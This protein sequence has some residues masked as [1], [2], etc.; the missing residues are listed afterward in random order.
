MS[1]L[2]VIP[3]ECMRSEDVVD[4]A[5]FDTSDPDSPLGVTC[6]S[7]VPTAASC[8][9]PA[10]ASRRTSSTRCSPPAP[11][12]DYA[13]SP[14]TRPC[15]SMSTKAYEC[16][17]ACSRLGSSHPLPRVGGRAGRSA[18]AWVG[19]HAR[20]L[21]PRFQTADSVQKRNIVWMGLVRK[22]T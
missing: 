19:E 4:V 3:M 18:R 16:T 10:V 11:A 13:R 12:A 22:R 15:T 20:F 5:G 2:S 1:S 8:M 9:W 7:D 21:C 17:S 14:G 6:V